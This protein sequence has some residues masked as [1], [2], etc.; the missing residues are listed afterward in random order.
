MRKQS[1]LI[2][3][4][5]PGAVEAFEPMLTAHGYHVTTAGDAALALEHIGRSTPDAMLVDLHLRNTNGVE[6]LRRIRTT[7]R[8]EIPAAVITGDYLIDDQ[9]VR[10]LEIL[11]ARIFFKPLWEEDLVK[12]V[13]ELMC[14]H[15][16]AVIS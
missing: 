3:D 13:G 12:I 9:T 6:F 14:A 8:A 10:D 11:N 2:V 16:R 4:D 7:S 5:D 15:G 1:V